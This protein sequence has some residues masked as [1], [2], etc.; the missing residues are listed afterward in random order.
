MSFMQ[1]HSFLDFKS[2]LI[3]LVILSQWVCFSPI[4]MS[5]LHRR[6]CQLSFFLVYIGFLIDHECEHSFR[7]LLTSELFCCDLIIAIYHNSFP[8]KILTSFHRNR[9]QL[10]YF[11]VFY[12]SSS[13]VTATTCWDGWLHWKLLFWA[14]KLSLYI[15]IV[16]LRAQWCRF[17][18]TIV[19]C[20][21][22]KFLCHSSSQMSATT[23]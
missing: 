21:I 10:L 17:N 12:N 11:E 4:T 14:I 15:I 16:F 2:S 22:L 8:P 23:H 9:C 1:F 19:D 18:V 5:S 3:F 7:L 13:L 6:R 20:F